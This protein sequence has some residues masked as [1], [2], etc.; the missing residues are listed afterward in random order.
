M[1]RL[2]EIL[3]A[4]KPTGAAEETIYWMSYLTNRFTVPA[5]REIASDLNLSRH[6]AL[7]LLCLG[8]LRPGLTA[9]EISALSG[10]PKNSVSRAVATLEARHLIRRS[11]G[12][13]DKRQ[14]PLSMT[15]QGRTLHGKINRRLKA[16]SRASLDALTDTERRQLGR[17]PAKLVSASVDEAD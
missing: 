1:T 15:A 7:I 5:Y 4:E 17:I 6:E 13:H 8:S 9:G 3:R 12:A 14:H 10:R 11:A 16:R 2:A